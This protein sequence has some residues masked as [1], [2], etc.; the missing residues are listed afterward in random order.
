MQANE[1]KMDGKLNVVHI[2]C[3]LCFFSGWRVFLFKK[4]LHLNSEKEGRE[5]FGE[6]GDGIIIIAREHREKSACC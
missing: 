6:N 3:V 1:T 2:R 5:L 4:K